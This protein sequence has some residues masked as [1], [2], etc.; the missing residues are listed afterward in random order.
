MTAQ[1]EL[2]SGIRELAE[3]NARRHFDEA[4]NAKREYGRYTVAGAAGAIALLASQFDTAGDHQR[5]LIAISVIVLVLSLFC[6]FYTMRALWIEE[7]ENAAK[8]TKWRNQTLRD[9]NSVED[10]DAIHI[11]PLPEPHYPQFKRWSGWSVGLLF[12]GFIWGIFYLLSFFFYDPDVGYRFPFDREELHNSV[13]N[14]ADS[15]LE[16]SPAP[17]EEYGPALTEPPAS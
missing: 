3:S 2:T 4:A 9:I 11:I 7:A 8:W 13:Q 12:Q 17:V 10:R 16:S 15:Q 14:N 5:I 6:S 1:D